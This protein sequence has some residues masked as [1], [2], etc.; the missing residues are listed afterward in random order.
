MGSL[1]VILKYTAWEM[2]RKQAVRGVCRA[3]SGMARRNASYVATV[4]YQRGGASAGGRRSRRT[5]AFH[6]YACSLR[7]LVRC[8]PMEGVV[9][10]GA[11]SARIMQAHV[12]YV[13]SFNH[14][15]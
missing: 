15:R 12:V 11:C 9:A 3:Q 2:R 14:G 8:R 1:F 7:E 6:I 13:M 4:Q 10:S 5:M